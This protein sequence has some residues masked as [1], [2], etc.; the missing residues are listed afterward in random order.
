MVEPLYD[1][2]EVYDVAY[3]GDLRDEAAWLRERLAAG[4]QCQ[5]VL[6]PGCGTGRH[7]RALSEVGVAGV[8][9]DASPAMLAVARRRLAD[10]PAPVTLVEDDLC[11][12]DLEHGV[13]GALCPL[14]TLAHLPDDDAMAAH[15]GRVAAHLPSGGRYL[16]QLDLRDPADPGASVGFGTWEATRGA[17]TVEAT[18]WV[19]AVDLAAGTEL[20]RAELAVRSGPRAGAVVTDTLRMSAWTPARWQAVLHRSPFT[21]LAA[22]DGEDPQR[23]S[24]PVGSPGDLRWHELVRV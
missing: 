3:S 19:L 15:L 17:W 12:L 9:V 16:V 5:R 14:N 1:E 13:D 10:A 21:Q 7:L 8:G 6:E 2:A 22:Y 18:W 24:A 23:P 4:G 11:T 20:H